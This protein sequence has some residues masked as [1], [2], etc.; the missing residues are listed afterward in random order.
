VMVWSPPVLTNIYYTFYHVKT[1]MRSSSV[2]SLRH[3]CFMGSVF[4]RPVILLCL[5][6][7][8]PTTG[9]AIG[10]HGCVSTP[11]ALS[12]GIR[13]TLQKCASLLSILRCEIQLL[14]LVLRVVKKVTA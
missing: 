12:S 11:D 4:I 10:K 13:R 6:N 2:F 8:L 5:I 7:P 1:G 3:P 9:P 14:P